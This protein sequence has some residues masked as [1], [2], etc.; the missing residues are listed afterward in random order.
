MDVTQSTSSFKLSKIISLV[1][2]MFLYHNFYKQQPK[3]P[4]YAVSI[5][6][7]ISFPNASFCFSPSFDKA[8]FL[9]LLL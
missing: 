7:M 4:L 1:F 8:Q 3:I 5:N 9:T 6:S 2:I